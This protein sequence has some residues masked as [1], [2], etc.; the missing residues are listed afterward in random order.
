MANWVTILQHSGIHS[1]M[2]AKKLQIELFESA[3][4]PSQSFFLLISVRYTNLNYF[5]FHERASLSIVALDRKCHIHDASRLYL[6]P[7]WPLPFPSERF[8]ALREAVFPCCRY[9]WLSFLQKRTNS[10]FFVSRNER[11]VTITHDGNIHPDLLMA[12][13]SRHPLP[14]SQWAECDLVTAALQPLQG[15]C[16]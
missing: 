3:P 11:N 13:L 6:L 2:T 7:L 1:F 14:P 5:I 15:C 4:W 8:W 12:S 16:E 10:Q 9:F